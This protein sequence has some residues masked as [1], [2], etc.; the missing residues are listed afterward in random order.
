ME[1]NERMEANEG[2]EANE[3]M[4]AKQRYL[5]KPWCKFYPPGVPE[6]VEIPPISLPCLFEQTA[7]KYAS[8]V[9]IHFYGT[10]IKFQDLKDQVLRMAN[11]LSHLGVKKG[12]RV[13]LYLLNTPQ[14]VISYLA[15]LRLGAILT[16]ISPVY[17]SPEVKHQLSDSGAKTVIC[18]DILFSNVE[19]TGLKLDHVIVTGIAEYLPWLKRA[20]GKS[21]LGRVAR[22]IEIPKVDLSA[23]DG[24]HQFQDLLKRYPPTPPE[25]DLDPLTDLA[26]LPY[27]GGTTGP[28]KGAM[29]THRNLLA[30]QRQ[31]TAFWPVMEPGKEVIIA[32]LPFYHIYGQIVAMVNS[33]FLGG[34][35]VLFT[36]PDVDDIIDAI[37][38]R[39]A[40]VLYG[41][42]TFFEYLKEY[43]RTG[44]AGWKRLKLITCGADTLHEA[45]ITSWQGRTG[46]K[47]MEGYGMTET[48]AVSH[49]NPLGRGKVGSFGIPIPNVLAAVVDPDTNAFVPPGEVG[50]MVLR[51]PNMMGGY[52]QNPAETGRTLVDIDGD[53]W[54]KTGDLVRMDDE[55]YFFFYDRKKDL[56]KYK[57]YSVFARDIE[58]HLM[59][60]PQIKAAGVIGVP[61]PTVGE[62][63]KAVIVLQNEARGKLS[64]EDIVAYCREGLAHYKVPRI[65]EFRGELPRTD[66]GKTSRRELREEVEAG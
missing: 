60:H 10:N 66:V 3:G 20:L 59:K 28:P 13:A 53:G 2:T 5:A 8:R 57:G 30:T 63:V 18:Q 38:D 41:V 19:K 4:D 45:T 31:T 58:E 37:D 7:D 36:T 27:T 17:T 43:H 42:P 23:A 6:T 24:V 55:G 56:I 54:L 50:E 14:F 47:I 48:T 61:D 33:L 51:G 39:G 21:L 12:D 40:T 62:I 29:L 64:E 49:A 26:V 65:I 16:P 11:A 34:T 25:V 1:I 22:D 9:A 46:S 32:F 35:M 44:Q 52:W 15:T